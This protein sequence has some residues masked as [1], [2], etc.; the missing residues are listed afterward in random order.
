[1]RTRRSSSIL[2]HLFED[3]SSQEQNICIIGLCFQ[4][5][6]A[7]YNL[8][9]SVFKDNEFYKNPIWDK[10]ENHHHQCIMGYVT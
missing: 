8:D 1:M 9:V 4:K 7:I 5:N 10:I 2:A 6:L 3:F